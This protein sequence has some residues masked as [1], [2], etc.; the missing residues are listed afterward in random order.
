MRHDGYLPDRKQ[1]GNE[2]DWTKPDEQ[3][4]SSLSP[5]HRARTRFAGPATDF[6]AA[7]T[8]LAAHVPL[9]INRKVYQ[10]LKLKALA[11]CSQP[12]KDECHYRE[13]SVPLSGL[14]KAMEKFDVT[15]IGGGLA[16]MAASIHLVRAGLRVICVE[17][18]SGDTDAVGESL[19]WS[20]PDLLKDLGLPMEELIRRGI[21]THKTTRHFQAAGWSGT[22]LRSWRLVWPRAISC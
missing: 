12:S 21:A 9:G 2:D 13:G 22:T 8:I 4:Q 1:S 15:V 3:F 20:A 7:H 6:F 17:A 14:D 19:D 5:L 16:G 10:N 11:A 18:A